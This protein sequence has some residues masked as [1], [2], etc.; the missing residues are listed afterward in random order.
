MS[1]PISHQEIFECINREKEW[2][3]DFDT[4]VMELLFE[5]CTTRSRDRVLFLQ[6]EGNELRRTLCE[7]EDNL[8]DLLAKA[9]GCYERAAEC[10]VRLNGEL[11]VLKAKS[12]RGR[13]A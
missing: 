7:L 5:P 6:Q 13:A 8:Y 1:K 4:R 10:S 2:L 9:Y 11:H 12:E 3:S